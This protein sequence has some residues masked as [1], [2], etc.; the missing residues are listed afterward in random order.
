MTFANDLCIQISYLI[1]VCLFF[2]ISEY[3]S[4]KHSL[5]LRQNSQRT[6]K[7]LGLNTD[8]RSSLFSFHCLFICCSV[9][10]NDPPLT[11]IERRRV[12]RLLKKNHAYLGTVSFTMREI[13]F[14]LQNKSVYQ[15]P[16][17][18]RQHTTNLMVILMQ[19]VAKDKEAISEQRGSF[20]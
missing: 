14:A 4:V 17:D 20:G 18:S 8:L 15:D 11:N 19:Q 5:S 9:L 1:K 13:A 16:C 2:R 12:Y 3:E 7:Y 10:T 6:S